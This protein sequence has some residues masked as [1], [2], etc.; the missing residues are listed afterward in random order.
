MDNEEIQLLENNIIGSFLL[1]EN[2]HRYIREFDTDFFITKKSK[3][4]FNVIKELFYN[5][6][7]I[8]LIT[9]SNKMS[10][11]MSNNTKILQELTQI[12]DD[13]VTTADIE[14][15]INK[16]KD[17]NMRVCMT[18]LLTNTLSEIRN[19]LKES[20]EIKKD[21][22]KNLV[23]L[24]D[25][26]KV[27][28]DTIDKVFFNT[29][30]DLEKKASRG[31]DYSLYSGFIAWDKITDGFHENELTCIGARPGTGKTAIAVNIATN[32]AKRGKKVYFCSL[33]MSPEQLM[34]RII[35]A[36][37]NINTQLFRNGRITEEE[38]KK[39]ADTTNDILEMSISIDTKT[40]TIEDLENVAILLREHEEVDIIIV[41][42]LTLLKS[43]SKYASRELEV[44]E[45][46]R[47]LKLLALDLK[48]PIVILVQLNRDAENRVPTMATIRESG[49]IEQNCDN[50]VFLHNP[51]AQGNAVDTIDFIIE[52][53][54]QGAT[55][56][57]K[58]KFDKRISLF[59]NMV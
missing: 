2:T 36:A 58:L 28:L 52:K 47:R 6:Q 40:R 4:I 21:L 45:I 24:K 5:K 23:L 7:D 56:S 10:N 38:Y 48:I 55:G 22:Q 11:G 37:S 51:N 42:Y 33:E 54:R 41:D 59:K 29:L 9:I 1:D 31:T 43:K 20:F 13:T 15:S 25:T 16:L 30:D 27:E 12:T 50:I 8:N 14:S 46:S 17:I 53:Q 49:S 57:F 44:A 18:N 34:H 26:S 19:G 3:T 32:I 39:I 35:A